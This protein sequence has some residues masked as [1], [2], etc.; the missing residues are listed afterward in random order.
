MQGAGEG[1]VGGREMGCVCVCSLG[2]LRVSLWVCVRR[3][4]W[5]VEWYTSEIVIFRSRKPTENI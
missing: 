2:F 3:T 5:F 1:G 4:V